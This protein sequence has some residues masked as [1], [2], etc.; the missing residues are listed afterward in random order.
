VAQALASA[1]RAAG[2]FG[3]AEET[4]VL[5]LCVEAGDEGLRRAMQADLAE[6]R[7][8]AATGR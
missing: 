4:L 5:A 6:V 1:Q 7:R 8:L 3:E 2:R